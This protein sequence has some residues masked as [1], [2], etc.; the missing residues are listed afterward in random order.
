MAFGNDAGESKFG[1]GKEPFSMLVFRCCC[2]LL[3]FPH[4]EPVSKRLLC[5][6]LVV[7]MMSLA[8]PSA[9]LAVCFVFSFSFSLFFL[10]LSSSLLLLFFSIGLVE[11]LTHESCADEEV[12]DVAGDDDDDEDDG[13]EQS[14]EQVMRLTEDGWTEGQTAD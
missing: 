5:G 4:F 12:V 2:F 14:A 10:L 7:W 11:R 9:L 6:S 1:I 13:M 3:L 8:F